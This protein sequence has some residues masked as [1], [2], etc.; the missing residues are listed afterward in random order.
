MRESKARK[1]YPTLDERLTL[2]EKRIQHLTK[3]K[4]ER[5]ETVR[6]TEALLAARR[7]AL[8]KTVDQLNKA[9]ARR[10]RLQKQK[11]GN[12]VPRTNRKAD[13]KQLDELLSVI[14]AKGLSLEDIVASLNGGT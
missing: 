14:K 7:G 3:V 11:S 6:K 13:R 12:A 1:P 8:E 9:L 2:A 4:A 5:E 10:E